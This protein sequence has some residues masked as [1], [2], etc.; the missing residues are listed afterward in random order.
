MTIYNGLFEPKKSAIKDCGAVQLA[1]AIDAPNKKVAESIMTLRNPG[2]HTRPMV[3]TIS[4]RNCGNTLKA[5][6][7]LP[8]A[9]SDESFAQQHTFDGEN[10][11]YCAG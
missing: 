4:N 6:R 3:T 10:D 7:C 2:N 8:L 11:F 1:I 5:S 9:S